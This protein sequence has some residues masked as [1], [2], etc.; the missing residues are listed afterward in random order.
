MSRREYGSCLGIEVKLM[1]YRLDNPHYTAV[2]KVSD[3]WYRFNDHRVTKVPV[4][5]LG[6]EKAKHL[7]GVMF[8]F[9]KINDS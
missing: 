1:H 9:K 8:F 7:D 6:R 3:E 2:A 5:I 4:K